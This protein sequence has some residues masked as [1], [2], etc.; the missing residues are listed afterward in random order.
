MHTKPLT[1]A[2][3]FFTGLVAA[4][5]LLL[6]GCGMTLTNLTPPSLAENPSQIYTLSLRVK[7]SAAAITQSSVVPFVVVGGQ[8]YKMRKSPLSEDLYEY[9]YQLPAGQDEIAY[10]FLVQFKIESSG[11]YSDRELFT[12]VTRA[13][14]ARR[15]V[16]SLE[17]PRGPV[18]SRVSVLGRGFSP[19]DVVML[20]DAA[21]RTVYDSP[22]SLSFFV[23]PVAASRSYN[24]TL[25]SPLGS[26][27]IG[28][29]RVDPSSVQVFPSSLH[30]RVGERQTIT[31]TLPYP[32]SQGGLLLD[33][34]TDI[35]ESVIMPEVL[36]PAGQNS[37]VVPIQGG[38]KGRGTLFLKGFGDGELTIPVTVE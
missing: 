21:A 30:L 2:R 16:V 12:E 33:I 19:Q 38:K 34:T 8:S 11:T 20:D 1:L 15:Y 14:V 9:D 29:F 3:I 37:I 31:F 24:V 26:S 36:V 32:A 10:Y 25:A 35:P 7:R 23:P 17:V 13:K 18:G 4:L 28:T 27:P 22:T 5:G 6:T